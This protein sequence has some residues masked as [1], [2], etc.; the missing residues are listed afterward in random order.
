MR[1]LF[2]RHADKE[3]L[4]PFSIVEVKENKENTLEECSFYLL[5]H[6]LKKGTLNVDFIV[7]SS[8]EERE[9][10]SMIFSKEGNFRVSGYR[11]GVIFE[12][13]SMYCHLAKECEAQLIPA[14]GNYD[15][16]IQGKSPKLNRITTEQ[17]IMASARGNVHFEKM[18]KIAPVSQWLGSLVSDDQ[19]FTDM[20]NTTG[21]LIEETIGRVRVCNE[22]LLWLWNRWYLMGVVSATDFQRYNAPKVLF[23]AGFNDHQHVPKGTG[24]HFISWNETLVDL[25]VNLGR[26]DEAAHA[27]LEMVVGDVM[28]GLNKPYNEEE[29]YEHFVKMIE[30]KNQCL[31]EFMEQHHSLYG[32]QL[33]IAKDKI[34]SLIRIDLV[35]DKTYDYEKPNLVYRNTVLSFSVC[36]SG[37]I[38]FLGKTQPEAHLS[39]TKVIGLAPL[40]SEC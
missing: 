16:G 2:V 17:S 9:D 7:V 25:S 34:K 11:G 31:V 29:S 20:V 21:C 1:F 27:E 35:T 15:A 24:Q 26:S 8:F 14:G 32:N 10:K 30:Y 23:P 19:R 37:V 28:V 18:E 5:E 38:A 22:R 33:N 39:L 4:Y 40:V 6:Y 13:G 3:F 36:L 12:H